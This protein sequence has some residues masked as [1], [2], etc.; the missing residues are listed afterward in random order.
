MVRRA[1]LTILLGVLLAGV[2]S[3]GVAGVQQRA[4]PPKPA[5][6]T[7]LYKY[8][9][10]SSYHHDPEAFTQGLVYHDG[11]LYESTGLHGKSSLRK[12]ELTTGKVL[13]KVDLEP[14]YFGEGLTIFRDRIYQ[15]T[16]LS[17]TGFIYDLHLDR[18]GEFHYEGEGWGLTH[19]SRY[20]IL[21]DGSNRLKFLDPKDFKVAR[22]I[23]VFYRGQPL[24][25]LNE[26]E[27]IN[28]QIY[29]NLWHKDLIARI[30]PATGNLLGMIDLSGLGSA[31]KLGSEDV[32]NGIA[33]VPGGEWL[34]VT[35]KR[36]PTL[37]KI[38]A[39]PLGE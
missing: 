6:D 28:G 18:V 12:V 31:L 35:G 29:S 38:R 39:V 7:K 20:L 32:L 23:E 21:S 26:L 10:L 11:Y 9:I 37:F 2:G 30:D 5:H 27:Y 3:G 22:S 4:T 14:K 19:D 1:Q 25:A 8:Q 16:W 33:Y 15:L 36:W 34:L 17:G 13:K 24:S